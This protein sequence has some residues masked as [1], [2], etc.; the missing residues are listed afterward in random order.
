MINRCCSCKKIRWIYKN[1][2]DVGYNQRACESCYKKS[3][4]LAKELNKERNAKVFGE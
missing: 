3:I 1:R 4:E 2:I